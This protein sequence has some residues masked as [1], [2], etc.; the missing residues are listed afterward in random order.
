MPK[1]KN[2]IVL[3]TGSTKS[4][5]LAINDDAAFEKQHQCVDYQYGF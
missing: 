4:I 1:L 3:I 5:G 2:K